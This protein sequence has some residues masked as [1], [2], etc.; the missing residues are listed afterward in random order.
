MDNESSKEKKLYDKLPEDINNLSGVSID[1]FSE[2]AVNQFKQGVSRLVEEAE[3]IDEEDIEDLLNNFDMERV[4]QDCRVK[5]MFEKPKKQK[6]KIISN[7]TKGFL[8]AA[9][10][11]MIF[12]FLPIHINESVSAFK[13]NLFD[14]IIEIKNEIFKLK[15][16]DEDVTED[17][18][19][20]DEFSTINFKTIEEAKNNIDV[21]F[22]YSTYIPEG[23]EISFIEYEKLPKDKYFLI[24][25][26]KN[27]N[28]ESIYFEQKN[29]FSAKYNFSENKIKP[30]PYNGLELYLSEGNDKYNV[31]W[32]NKDVEFYLS[33][34][35]NKDIVFKFIDK[36]TY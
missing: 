33:G 6:R 19:V 3:K 18:M 25:T 13:F 28:D 21:N 1:D 4:Y 27:K 34:I 9:S 23:Y 12:A 11:L 30:I 35:E 29:R 17:E 24:I 36:L 31:T 32:F 2:N 20:D 5:N 7:I 8:V 14:S 16:T 26:Y 22:L 10:I 15:S